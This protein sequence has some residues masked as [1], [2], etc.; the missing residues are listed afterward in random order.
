MKRRFLA[1]MMAFAITASAASVLPAAT[2]NADW[3]EENGKRYYYNE[4][5][6]MI[7][8]DWYN[9]KSSDKWYHFDENGVMETN[10]LIPVPASKNFYYLGED[11]AMVTN[12]W[13]YNS[14]NKNWYYIGEDDLRIKNTDKLFDN[15]LRYRFRTDGSMDKWYYNSKENKY[16]YLDMN[17]R[18]TSFTPE[19]FS[20]LDTDQDSDEKI[21]TTIGF[22]VI[23]QTKKVDGITYTLNIDLQKWDQYTTPEQIWHISNL[24]WNCYPKMYTRFVSDVNSNEC[25]IT[26]AIEN[27][28]YSPANCDEHRIHLNDQYLHNSP[29]D[30]DCVTHELAHSLQNRL[31]ANGEWE[32]WDGNYCGDS[33]YIENFADYCRYVYAYKGGYYNDE[34]GWNPETVKVKKGDTQC[35]NYN[36]IRFLVW[37]DYNFSDKDNDIIVKFSDVCRNKNYKQNRWDNEAWA[38]IFANYNALKNRSIK[39]V[40]Q[41]YLN[42]T[43]FSKADATVPKGHFGETSQLIQ[44][45][46]IREKLAR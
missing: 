25:E 32:G 39:D 18:R 19:F 23:T 40:W 4:D 6:S 44:R 24:F 15:G 43:G 5:G 27:E 46:N 29:N 26:I 1:S 12:Q 30:Y 45:Y 9:D 38:E 11:G 8:N 2:A 42:D 17:D 13:F 35:V 31:K 28:G 3:F 34:G 22:R 10:K 20:N 41:Q 33:D 7:V 21:V 36:S 14:A 16:Y 37:L